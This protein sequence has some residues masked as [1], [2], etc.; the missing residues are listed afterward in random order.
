[1]SS[2][3]LSRFGKADKTVQVTSLYLPFFERNKNGHPFPFEVLQQRID[4]VMPGA[5]AAGSTKIVIQLPEAMLATSTPGKDVFMPLDPGLA[6]DSIFTPNQAKEFLERIDKYQNELTKKWNVDVDFVVHMLEEAFNPDNSR[7]IEV[8]PCIALSYD[9]EGMPEEYPS[10]ESRLVVKSYSMYLE[11]GSEKHVTSKIESDP[12]DGFVKT[13]MEKGGPPSP[14]LIFTRTG[15]IYKAYLATCRD[16]TKE[17]A[18]RDAIIYGCAS[19]A[20]VVA[21]WEAFARMLSVCDGQARTRQLINGEAS[22]GIYVR[23]QQQ[24]GTATWTRMEPL[25][26]LHQFYHNIVDNS[27]TIYMSTYNI[28]EAGNLAQIIK[29]GFQ[30]GFPAAFK[31]LY[32]RVIADSIQK[33]EANLGKFEDEP[34]VV[35]SKDNVLDYSNIY[36]TPLLL[37]ATRNTVLDPSDKERPVISVPQP[38][39]GQM[40]ERDPND[41]SHQVDIHPVEIHPVDIHPVDIHEFKGGKPK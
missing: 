24:D 31:D 20:P 2:S 22:S 9:M 18:T 3:L 30:G 17:I 13:V 38:H 25:L 35:G 8:T 12:V 19:G 40:P 37:E 33:A 41:V 29:E 32:A 27:E 36:Q 15:S 23:E 4:R 16:F 5:L 1:M 6:D 26:E 21:S 10:S 14:F 11:S 39:S 28:P 7:K 34:R